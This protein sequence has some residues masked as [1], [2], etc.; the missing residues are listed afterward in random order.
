MHRF[1]SPRAH[2]GK[3]E[4]S[5]SKEATGVGKKIASAGKAAA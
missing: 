1:F 4:L 5:S 3:A 2:H